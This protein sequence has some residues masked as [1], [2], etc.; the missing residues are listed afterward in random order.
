MLNRQKNRPA[1]QVHQIYGIH[2]GSINN[3][4]LQL[5]PYN[6]KYN[7]HQLNHN[8]SNGNLHGGS[9]NNN[10]SGIGPS[11]D[12]SLNFSNITNEADED[13]LAI[14]QSTIGT[15]KNNLNNINKLK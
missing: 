11:K 12:N 4:A 7:V 10:A 8:V 13:P 14:A 9:H 5:N 6:I 3:N 2:G 1:N 15:M